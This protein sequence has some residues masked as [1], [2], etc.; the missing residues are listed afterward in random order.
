MFR[1]FGSFGVEGWRFRAS[2]LGIVGLDFEGL[3]DWVQE[4]YIYIYIYI[5]ICMFFFG[6][7]FGVGC[8]G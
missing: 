8:E 7:G 3:Q 4:L 5:Y 1:A 2:G 6:R